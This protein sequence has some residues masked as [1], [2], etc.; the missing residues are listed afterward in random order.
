MKKVTVIL[1]LFL[2]VSISPAQSPDPNFIKVNYNC[3]FSN[4]W[5]VFYR[6]LVCNYIICFDNWFDNWNGSQQY[7]APDRDYSNNTWTGSPCT[8]TKCDYSHY[9]STD[10]TIA[11]NVATT[12][13]SSDLAKISSLGF[14]EIRLVGAFMTYTNN[15][16]CFPTGEAL[17]TGG[18]RYFSLLDGFITQARANGLRVILLLGGNQQKNECSDLTSYKKFITLVAD[19]FKNNTNIMAYDLFNEP[20]NTIWPTDPVNSKYHYAKIVSECVSSIKSKDINHLTTIGLWGP[21]EASFNFDP[22]LMPIDFVS[23]HI[24]PTTKNIST[25]NSQMDACLYWLGK[26]IN[27]PWIIGETGYSA[28]NSYSNNPDVGTEDDQKTYAAHTM[29]MSVNCNCK[30]Y[31]W[32][33]YQ[34]VKWGNIPCSGGAC[35]SYQYNKEDFFGM[36]YQGG[37]DPNYQDPTIFK[38]I[39]TYSLSPFPTYS[40]IPSPTTTI[41]PPTGYATI[42]NGNTYAFSGQVVDQ[43]NSGLL[44]NAI[45]MAKD[46]WGNQFTTFTASN[47]TFNINCTP[48]FSITNLFITYPGY[49]TFH[50]TNPLLGSNSTYYLVKERYHGW[51]KEWANAANLN[52]F[53]VVDGSGTDWTIKSNDKYYKGDF[54][55]DG[56]QDLLCVNY[57]AGGTTDRI[58]VLTYRD[59]IFQYTTY[60][61]SAIYDVTAGWSVLW[62]N[63]SNSNC[64]IYPYRNNLVVGDFD[65]DRKDDIISIGSGGNSWTTWFTFAGTSG[66]NWIDSDYGVGGHPMSQM[67]GYTN[68]VI[69]G[70]FYGNSNG[71]KAIMAIAPTTPK[72]I[73]TFQIENGV[74]SWKESNGGGANG[75]LSP[76]NSFTAQLIPGDFDGDGFTE[77]LGNAIPT[78]SM[79]VNRFSGTIGNTWITK[80]SEGYNANSNMFPYRNNLQVGNYDIDGSEE[81]L[82]INSNYCVS[83]DFLN[84]PWSLTWD[85]TYNSVISDWSISNNNANGKYLF[86]NADKQTKQ[87]ML[88]A[89]NSSTVN[90]GANLYSF[91]PTLTTNIEGPYGCSTLRLAGHTAQSSSISSKLSDLFSVFPNPSN[92]S[93]TI[94]SD[95]LI[96]EIRVNDVLGNIVYEEKPNTTELNLK[97]E[98]S[99]IYFVS[100]KTSEGASTKKIIVQN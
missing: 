74:W 5:G 60:Q 10:P 40:A 34:E 4:P 48:S 13:I 12:K 52:K 85:G 59:T 19:Y 54:N 30:G 29:T 43:T 18:P 45:V 81:I 32:W 49:S 62:D 82:G 31:S 51:A 100:V 84:T 97:I 68:N 90:P 37:G 88:L 79:V 6:P 98:T 65:G 55:G 14:T 70:N 15:A 63:G 96:G 76:L 94:K 95:I 77:V 2:F 39:A 50:L 87:Q 25:A 36:C 8:G 21:G 23:F 57:T 58:T 1:C 64:N 16:F 71:K 72:W 78:G 89:V 27:I 42:F 9:F 44:A 80:W 33:Q 17:S 20:S 56:K 11:Y 83:F 38:P 46:Q 92:G 91:M 66:W 53:H 69:A 67:S 99:G 61:G 24:Y 93:V 7:I 26:T 47:G 75:A 86:L 22:L 35:G 73:T 41:S 28:N 3:G